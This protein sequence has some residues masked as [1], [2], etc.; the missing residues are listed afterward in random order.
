[1]SDMAQCMSGWGKC[2]VWH[3]FP[4]NTT[5][6]TTTNAY[7]CMNAYV[8]CNIYAI[9]VQQIAR[10]HIST[11]HYDASPAHPLRYTVRFQSLRH[12]IDLWGF[13]VSP[14]TTGTM[15]PPVQGTTRP[16]LLELKQNREPRV[17]KNMASFDITEYLMWML[18]GECTK[19]P[20]LYS[21]LGGMAHSKKKNSYKCK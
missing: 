4:P 8:V 13:G 19:R 2:D 9:Y 16:C 15:S 10:T 17:G 21:G 5:T 6:T 7:A 3:A 1:M 14:S 20:V 11:I 12:V 18:L